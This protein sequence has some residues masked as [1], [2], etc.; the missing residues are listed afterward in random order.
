[1]P[2]KRPFHKSLHE[3]HDAPAKEAMIE[4]LK[5]IKKVEAWEN[6]NRY[7]IDVLTDKYLYEVEVKASWKTDDYKYKDLHIPYRKL[8]WCNDPNVRF[9]VMNGPMTVGAFV[10][11]IDVLKSPVE[12]F[13]FYGYTEQFFVIDLDKVKFTPLKEK[14]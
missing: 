12:W 14:K 9:V 1:M 4:Y 10:K 8:K 2:I 5:K 11:A 7:G 6:P 13:T 3:K